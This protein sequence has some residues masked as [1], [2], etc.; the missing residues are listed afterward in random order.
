MQE[1]ITHQAFKTRRRWILLACLLGMFMAAIEATIVGTAMPAIVAELGDVGLLGWVFSAYMVAQALTIP[2]YG[3]LADLYGRGKVFSAGVLIFLIGSTLCG[4][5]RSLTQLIVFRVLQGM[6]AG[7]IMPVSMTI[8]GDLY[9]GAERGRVQGA[10]SSVW[11]ISAVIGPL[12]GALIVSTTGWPV[13]FWLNLPVGLASI[14]LLALFLKEP[15][16]SPFAGAGDGPSGGSQAASPAATVTDSAWWRH[17]VIIAGNL[18]SL[19]IGA[20]MMGVI[21]FM[22]IWVQCVDGMGAAGAGSALAVMS[23]SWPVASTITGRSLAAQGSRRMAI[24]GG[25]LLALGCGLLAMLSGA[26]ALAWV[27]AGSALIGAGMGMCN[28][29]YVVSVQSSST[30]HTRGRATAS[31]SFSRILGS[32][33]GAAVLGIILNVSIARH[34]PG[35]VDPVERLMDA[36]RRSAL[37]PGELAQ[38]S[39]GVSAALHQVFLFGCLFGFAA[40]AVGW[41]YPHKRR[42]AGGTQ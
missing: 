40:L 8:V 28:T 31:V 29:T 1:T 26:S 19:A 35:I 25:A 32:G 3:R 41:L 16:T 37:A 36:A 39:A 11:G 10:L 38:M 7:A 4:F 20:G 9:K 12:L 14:V 42:T 2:L 34:L 6:G 21:V 22:P 17:P 18:G 27:F 5:S 30:H 13:V 33:L 23:L 15:S 24:A